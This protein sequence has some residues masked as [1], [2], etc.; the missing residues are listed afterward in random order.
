MNTIEKNLSITI[1]Q[2]INK[3]YCGQ[4]VI[5]AIG[6]HYGMYN[7]QDALFNIARAVEKDLKSVDRSTGMKEDDEGTGHLGMMAMAKSYGLKGFI[8]NG[9][10]FKEV[11]YFIDNNI[12]VL[13]DWQLLHSSDGEHGHYSLLTGYKII[14]MTNKRETSLT[15]L[16]PLP[17]PDFNR[18]NLDYDRVY[19]LWYDMVGNR[20]FDRWMAAFYPK[21][22]KILPPSKG[23]II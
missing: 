11:R 21:D 12:P 23:L 10:G 13:I 19:E 20:M 4:S 7:S 6:N 14:H 2:Q 17:H 5:Q 8:K 3:T 16:D 18:Y 1:E 22:M 15:I 9:A